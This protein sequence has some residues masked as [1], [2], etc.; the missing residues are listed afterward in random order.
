[1]PVTCKIKTDV[2]VYLF[3]CQNNSILFV[4]CVRT[5]AFQAEDRGIVITVHT[6]VFFIDVRIDYYIWILPP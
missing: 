3:I 1:M 4:V 5:I 6:Y 2:E